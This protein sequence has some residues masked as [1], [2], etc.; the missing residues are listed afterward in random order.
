MTLSPEEQQ[1]IYEEEKARKEAKEL[2]TREQN[3][4]KKAIARRNAKRLG[5][6]VIALLAIAWLISTFTNSNDGK[7]QHIPTL[8][9]NTLKGGHAACAS[10]ELLEGL[11]RAVRT[12]DVR[13]GQ[14][15]MT[16]GCISTTQGTPVSVLDATWSEAVKVRAYVGDQVME[17][18]TLSESLQN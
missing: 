5:I 4:V 13:A 14:Y 11:A 16:H 9:A 8:R 15:L 10:K 7:S 2:L 17:L 3:Q 1:R 18:W 6:G 12:N